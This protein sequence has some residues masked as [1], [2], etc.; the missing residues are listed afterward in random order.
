MPNPHSAHADIRASATGGYSHWQSQLYFSATGCSDPRTNG[1]RYEVAVPL[2]PSGLAYGLGLVVW[3]VLGLALNRGC[4]GSASDSPRCRLSRGFFRMLFLPA[5]L[6]QRPRLAAASALALT[7]V[8]CAILA[9]IWG[10]GRSI[11]LSVAGFFPISDPSGYWICANSLLDNGHFGY[12]PL[13]G[14]WCMRRPIYPT[15]LAG[16]SLIGARHL[17]LTLMLQAAIVGTAIFV[18]VRQLSP[19]VPAF[20]T[21]LCA[22]LLAVYASGELL[23]MTM[24]ENAGLVFGCLALAMLL[25]AAGR[26]SLPWVLAGSFLM[27]VALNARAGAFFVLPA[28]VLWAGV[29]AHWGRRRVWLWAAATAMAILAGFAVQTGLLLAVG[30]DATASHGNFSYVLYGLSVG[31][32]SWSQVLLDHPELLAGD[33]DVSRSHAIYALAWQNLSSQP[34]VFFSGMSKNLSLYLANG[35]FGYDRLGPLGPVAKALWWLAWPYLLWRYRDPRYL[36]L[37]LISLGIAAS[38]P[39]L[40]GDGGPRIF[41]AT[42]AADAAQ[43]A[44]G[45]AMIG[46]AVGWLHGV[47]S[48]YPMS[49]HAWAPKA[50]GPALEAVAALL[51]L[52]L[53]ILPFTPIA[54]LGKQQPIA[55]H[56]CGE[57]QEAVATR[58]NRDGTVSLN[59]V[60]DDRTASLLRGE[61]SRD[62]LFGGVP[63][64]AWWRDDLLSISGSSLVLAYQ[65]RADDPKR[66][67]PYHVYADEDLSRYD[68]KLVVLCLDTASDT[69][70]LFGVTYRKLRSI[71]ELEPTIDGL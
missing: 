62:A 58:L 17:L 61:V 16:L 42:M 23:P 57:N 5:S 50:R 67:G 3:I 56:G 69:R 4:A 32:K 10:E 30:G 6:P 65:L 39:L 12:P 51:V 26:P 34:A 15:F 46:L 1:R 37:A 44:L 11:G 64:T 55:Y 18:L 25:R 35:T 28:L 7:A 8:C 66:P 54:R 68:G 53:L 31:G 24:S 47:S 14:Q 20:A 19:L 48:G 36:L 70:P 41:A 38:A 22:I 60:G 49:G 63:T 29:V 9:W 2:S 13:T 43:I 59:M 21:F 27:S 40:I 52:T 71:R 45:I 33:S